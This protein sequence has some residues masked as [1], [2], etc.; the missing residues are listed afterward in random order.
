LRRADPPSKESHRLYIGLRNWRR[1][2]GPTKIYKIIIIIIIIKLP[3]VQ[4]IKCYVMKMY[5][6]VEV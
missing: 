5:G 4:I 2:E 6:A 3:F 1:G